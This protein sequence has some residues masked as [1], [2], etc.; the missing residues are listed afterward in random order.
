MKDRS[1]EPGDLVRYDPK[2]WDAPGKPKALLV[3]ITVGDVATVLVRGKL[4]RWNVVVFEKLPDR[5][6]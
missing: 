1:F 3:L 2:R 5:K 6:E 4:E